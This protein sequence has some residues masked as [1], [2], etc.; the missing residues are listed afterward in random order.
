MRMCVSVGM[1]VCMY[2]YHIAVAVLTLAREGVCVLCV[3][4]V[5]ACI[6]CGR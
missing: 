6:A 2:G 4:H 3:W 1:Y 5:C